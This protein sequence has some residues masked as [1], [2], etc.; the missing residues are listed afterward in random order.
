MMRVMSGCALLVAMIAATIVPANAQ[1]PARAGVLSC[2]GGQGGSYI[3][4]SMRQLSCAFSPDGGRP[5][6]YQAVLYRTGVDVGWTSTS[7]ISFAVIGPAGR[8]RPGTL[9]GSYGGVS[10]GASVGFGGRGNVLVGGPNNA[11]ALQPL[12]V[13][14][15]FG[16]NAG[17]GVASLA[18]TKG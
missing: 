15:Q 12:S 16:L 8:V 14:G 6:A 17:A 18:L 7:T 5:R 3:I 13:E 11:F 4:G 1:A 10:A 9:V 2:T